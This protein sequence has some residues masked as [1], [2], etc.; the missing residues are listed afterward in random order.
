[1]NHKKIILQVENLSKF[2]I[3]RFQVK[4]AVNDVSF[5]VKER[6]IVGLIG[7]SGSGK[8]TV[9]SC[10]VRLHDDYS[11]FVSL[12]DKIV[13]GLKISRERNKFLRKNMQMIFQ[14]PHSSLNPQKN[15]FAILKEPLVVNGLLKN[16][17]KDILKDLHDVQYEYRYDFQTKY[18]ETIIDILENNL[19]LSAKGLNGWEEK[20]TNLTFDEY[21]KV[22]DAFNAYY[23]FYENNN[24]LEAESIGYQYE[25]YEDLYQFYFQKQKAFRDDTPQSFSTHVHAVDLEIETLKKANDI[26]SE[27][28]LLKQAKKDLSVFSKELNERIWTNLNLLQAFRHQFK[29]QAQINFQSALAASDKKIWAQHRLISTVNNICAKALQINLGWVKF[30][31][32]QNDILV[33]S[34]T[35]QI[36]DF[37]NYLTQAAK[38]FIVNFKHDLNPDDPNFSRKF[39]EKIKHDFQL[40]TEKFYEH[41]KYEQ[42]KA[43]KKIKILKTK[44]NNLKTSS[45]KTDSKDYL[46]KLNQLLEKRVAAASLDQT[47]FESMLEKYNIGKKERYTR[48]IQ[49]EEE[50]K[51]KTLETQARILKLFDLRH[52]EFLVWAKQKMTEEN[53]NSS[54]IEIILDDYKSKV[55][56]KQESFTN[57][58]IETKIL[59]KTFDEVKF[60]YGSPT[61]TLYRFLLKHFFKNHTE[62]KKHETLVKVIKIFDKLHHKFKLK[63]LSRSICSG[64][65]LR[66]KIYNALADVGLLRQFAYRYPHAFSGGQRQ[67]IVIAR[68]LITEPKL[69]VADEPIASLDISI[70]AQIVNL[71]K[72]LGI[73]KNIGIIFIAHDLSMVEYIADKILIMH[74]GRIVEY[75]QTKK[76]YEKPLHPYT[77]NLFDA[78]P[79]MSNANQAFV[80]SQVDTAYLKEQKFPNIVNYQEIEPDHFLFGT[81]EQ[82]KRWTK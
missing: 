11:G 6:E 54:Q 38:D 31:L 35:N 40:E 8:T 58:Q 55:N 60:L 7:E 20:L 12:D 10:L 32:K 53:F 4:H 13:S 5:N 64:I 49:L 28:Y 26:L 47:E 27:E 77:K 68:A 44:I 9:G 14:D 51:T 16:S 15:V 52:K 71:L 80:N 70:Q 82:I 67:R 57:F 17:V 34:D 19:K 46:A 36:K 59:K 66:K 78:I 81:D 75:G 63:V 79:K 1:M 73:K 74:L 21:D 30:Y 61:K 72:E 41:A 22:D 33:Y 56:K 45:S 50:W 23:S 62:F 42:N 25:K 48:L 29:Y 69:I 76:I 18:Y 37:A 3:N 24:N 2:F 39:I 65:I 43:F